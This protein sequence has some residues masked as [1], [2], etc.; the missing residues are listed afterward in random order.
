MASETNDYSDLIEYTFINYYN[1]SADDGI[2]DNLREAAENDFLEIHDVIFCDY[3]GST[4]LNAPAINESMRSAQD[5]GVELYA[6]RTMGTAPE[7]LDYISDGRYKALK[8]WCFFRVDWHTTILYFF[9][10]KKQLCKTGSAKVG[11]DLVL[12]KKIYAESENVSNVPHIN[13]ALITGYESYEPQF[14]ALVSRINGNSIYNIN[15]SITICVLQVQ[16][17]LISVILTLSM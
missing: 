2:S 1:S 6:L 13:I 17:M 16:G 12:L 4:I 11:T 9:G 14:N 7:Y 3:L 15:V 5:N 8:M 10:I